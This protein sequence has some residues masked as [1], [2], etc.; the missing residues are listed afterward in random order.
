VEAVGTW[1]ESPW[2]DKPA[3]MVLSAG[4][5]LIGGGSAAGARVQIPWGSGQGATPV[6]LASLSA[7]AQTIMQRAIEW[8]AQPSLFIPTEMYVHDITMGWRKQAN[9]YY[10]QATVEVREDGGAG[11][12]GVTVTGL[13]SGATT[14]SDQGV[15]GVDGTVMVESS[16][17]KDGGTYTFTIVTL[18]K[19]GYLYNALLNWETSDWITAP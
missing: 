10:G 16:G 3:L 11:I 13:W 2:T 1:V 5:A 15:T 6:A 12:E 8:A 14:G 9:K 18:T 17:V 19:D 7:D 4:A